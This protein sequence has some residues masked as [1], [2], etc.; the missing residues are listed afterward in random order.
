MMAIRKVE[1]VERWMA[2]TRPHIVLPVT[3]ADNPL[4]S[5]S[6]AQSVSWLLRHLPRHRDALLCSYIAQTDAPR[7]GARLGT[8]LP[9]ALIRRSSWICPEEGLTAKSARL[10]RRIHLADTHSQ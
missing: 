10:T 9:N 8:R 1:V 7:T 3:V 5:T 6:G 4:C 2:Q